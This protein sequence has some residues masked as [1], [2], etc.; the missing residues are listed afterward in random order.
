[1]VLDIF[2]NFIGQL[3]ASLDQKAMAQ[4]GK[5]HG[6]F[7]ELGYQQRMD[8]VNFSLRCDDGLSESEYSR[9]DIILV[10][11]SRS[12]KTPICLYL[13]M[14]YGI[15]AANYPLTEDEGLMLA[16]PAVLQ[17]HRDKLLGLTI[18]PERWLRI[19]GRTA[20]IR[21]SSVTTPSFI[22]TLRSTRTSTR[23]PATSTSSSVLKS[24]ICTP[25]V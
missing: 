15:F 10:G 7:D 17:P 24:V 1:M 19:V 14:Q 9:A 3:E 8:A 13:A 22:G 6:L 25:V 23:L 16:L 2:E 20:R 11:V 18:Q 12:G 21:V 5:L 4:T